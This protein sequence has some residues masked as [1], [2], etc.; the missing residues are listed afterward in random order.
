SI[1]NTLP[2]MNTLNKKWAIYDTS[3]CPQCD[4]REET[5]DHLWR[6]EKAVS[7]VNSIISSFHQKYCIPDR[8]RNHTMLALHSIATIDLTTKIAV[9]LKAKQDEPISAEEMRDKITKA[10]LSL[11]TKGRKKV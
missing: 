5:N 11:I 7:A 4:T 3:T 1:T 8:M 9:H 2:T 10:Y 6:C